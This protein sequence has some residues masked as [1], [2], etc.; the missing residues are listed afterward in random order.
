MTE[1]ETFPVHVYECPLC[2]ELH[3]VEKENPNYM[4]TWTEMCPKV[5]EPIRLTNTYFID[6]V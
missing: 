6:T 5:G 1:A 4:D 2:G 3:Q